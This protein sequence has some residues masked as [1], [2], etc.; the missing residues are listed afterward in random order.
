VCY[1]TFVVLLSLFSRAG[2]PVNRINIMAESAAK[3]IA[4]IQM[5]GAAPSYITRVQSQWNL[6]KFQAVLFLGSLTFYFFRIL[7]H[8]RRWMGLKDDGG[9]EG[10]LDERLKQTIEQEFPGIVID[11]SVFDS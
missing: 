2:S 11:D 1:F 5:T 7:S 9:F 4:L 8:V 10:A 6:L 3:S